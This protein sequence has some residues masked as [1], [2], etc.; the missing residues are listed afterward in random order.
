MDT[1]KLWII[2]GLVLAVAEL[3]LVPAQFLLIALGVCAVLVGVLTWGADLGYS[4]QLTWFAALSVVL[5]PLF[6]FQWRRRAPVRYAGTAGETPTAPQEA[7]VVGTAPLTV[8]L[9]GDRFP[10]RVTDGSEFQVGDTVQVRGFSGITA[11]VS[12]KP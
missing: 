9:Q 5:V 8:K 11:L 6:V 3:M 10:A 12:R 1:W 2:F 7:E 4:A